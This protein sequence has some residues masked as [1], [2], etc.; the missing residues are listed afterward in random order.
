MVILETAQPCKFDQ[1]VYNTLGI[2]APR[3]NA[4]VGLE[5]KEQRVTVLPPETDQVIQF[6]RDNV[7]Q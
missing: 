6:I 2:T 5:E 7:F 3:P 4:L 1:M